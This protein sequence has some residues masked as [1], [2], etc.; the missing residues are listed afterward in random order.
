M[1]VTY[2]KPALSGCADVDGES[3]NKQAA[4]KAAARFLYM[5]VLYMAP[6]ETKA[7]PAGARALTYFTD[8]TARRRQLH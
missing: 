6:D 8:M 4:A 3:E 2:T 7:K 1:G 5:V